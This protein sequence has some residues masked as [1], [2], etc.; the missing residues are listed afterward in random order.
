MVL[1]A[2]LVRCTCYRRSRD[3]KPSRSSASQA[4]Q[5]GGV[6]AGRIVDVGSQ[7][8]A[9]GGCGVPACST[10]MLYAASQQ[11][12]ATS[13]N[14][15]VPCSDRLG[16]AEKGDERVSTELVRCNNVTSF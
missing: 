16:V 12:G 2:R 4:R 6:S 15:H 8:C 5:A 13:T 10:K 7:S 11:R 3:N 1:T 14:V 9:M